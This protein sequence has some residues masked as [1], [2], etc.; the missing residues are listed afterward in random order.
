MSDELGNTISAAKAQGAHSITLRHIDAESDWMTAE[1]AAAFLKKPYAEFRKSLAAQLPR[2]KQ[3]G[4]YLYRRS[5]L[6]TWLEE[7]IELGA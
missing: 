7:G 1:E 3:T 4:R 6:N 5:D 2:T